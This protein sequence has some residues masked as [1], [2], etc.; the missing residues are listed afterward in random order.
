MDPD[1]FIHILESNIKPF[2]TPV[3]GRTE[4]NCRCFYC[5]DSSNPIKG[6]FYIKVPIH[7]NDI[8]YYYCQKCHSTGVV[9][10]NKLMEW[11]VYD[12]SFGIELQQYISKAMKDA[13]NTKF[14]SSFVQIFNVRNT[15][16]RDDKL[17][18]YKL[19]YINNR[20]GTN[21]TFKDC[22][23]NKIVLNLGDLL[24]ENRINEL[25]RDPKIVD[26]MD[27][28]FVG[29]LSYD[30]GFANLRNLELKNIDLYHSINK[31]YVNYNIFGKF[32]NSL[33]FYVSPVD[34]DLLNPEPIDMR[35]AEGVFDA[36]SIKYNVVRNSGRN[37]FAAVCGSNYKS[38]LYT[39]LSVIKFHNL[40]VHFY[41]DTDQIGKKW[42]IR[43][44]SDI[45]QAYK[46]PMYIHTNSFPGE[47]DFGV[48][49]DKIKES[50]MKI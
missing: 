11:G 21:L 48:P 3:A 13:K 12:S 6:H 5:A 7:E 35:L 33:K 30:N 42:Y 22:I 43:E 31:R 19:K 27:T 32:D 29:F 47:K 1:R 16:I 28:A 46:I 44:L 38:C 9:T 15:V 10:Q 49:I 45:L 20:L 40:R 37:I 39:L 34:I 17:S 50:I 24:R 18:Q 23:E 14:V 4:V 25:T 2:A 36:L 8:P 41:M 26:A